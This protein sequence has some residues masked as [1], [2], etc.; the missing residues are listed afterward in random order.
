MKKSIL[1]LAIGTILFVAFSCGTAHN[2]D[3]TNVDQ[4]GAQNNTG[5][6][7]NSSNE[8]N[9]NGHNSNTGNAD[10]SGNNTG[11]TGVNYSK[12]RK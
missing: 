6:T 11:T 5:S 12:T 10:S 9:A 8:Q 1:T 2:D 3:Q 4:T 7:S